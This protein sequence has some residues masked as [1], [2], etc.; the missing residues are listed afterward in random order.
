[1]MKDMLQKASGAHKT[2]EEQCECDAGWQGVEILSVSL[3]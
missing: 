3:L 2:R 1:M